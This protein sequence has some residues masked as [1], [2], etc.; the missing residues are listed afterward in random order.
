MYKYGLHMQKT[1]KKCNKICKIFR[2]PNFAYFS[3]ICTCH[4]ADEVAVLAW[5]GVPVPALVNLNVL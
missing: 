3:C 4:F 5:R 2:S 1:A